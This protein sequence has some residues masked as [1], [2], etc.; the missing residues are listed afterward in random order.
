[1]TPLHPRDMTTGQREEFATYLDGLGTGR[2][3]T[4][5][6]LHEMGLGGSTACLEAAER[7]EAQAARVRKGEAP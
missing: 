1:M 2:R 7:R 5:L 4:A 6:A 3:E